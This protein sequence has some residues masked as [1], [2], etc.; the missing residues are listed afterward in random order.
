ME[1]Q[2]SCDQSATHHGDRAVYAIV[3]NPLATERSAIVRLPVSSKDTFEVSRLDEVGGRNGPAAVQQSVETVPTCPKCHVK[4]VLMFD[5]G[6]LPPVGA[7]AFRIS[8]AVAPPNNGADGV[9]EARRE[10]LRKLREVAHESL[11]VSNG[12]VSATFDTSTGKIKSISSNNIE[13]SIDHEW[14]YYR[15]YDTAFDKSE[16]DDSGQRSGA[17]IFRPS[18]PEELLTAL[19]PSP[20]GAKIVNTSVSIEVHVAFKEPWMKQVTRV[21]NDQP[22]IEVEYTIGPIPIEDGRGKEVVT[23]YRSEIR[24]KGVFFT[25]S[26]GREFQRRQRNS[27]PT[28]DLSVYEPVAGNYYPVNAAMYLEDDEASLAVLVDRSQGGASLFDGSLEL[29]VQRRIVADDGRGVDE[30]LNETV[31]GTA[32]YPPYGDSHRLGEGVVIRGTHRI[33]VSPS[34]KNGGIG[35]ASLCRSTMDSVFAQPVVL[36]GSAP[37]D[38][39][40]VFRRPVFS[41]I[42]QSFPPNVMLITFAKLPSRAMPTYLVRLAHQYGVGEDDGLSQPAEVDLASLF[43][44]RTIVGVTEKTLSGNLD[45]S[46]YLEGRKI[47]GDEVSSVVN[48][49]VNT[50]VVVT[51]MNIRTFEVSVQVALDASTPQY[52]ESKQF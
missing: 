19:S 12:L 8:K 11:E 33:L 14:G 16:V 7:V 21:L 10:V 3:Y 20:G 40:V 36:V 49:D 2:S 13:L 35:G 42:Q 26:N 22:Y 17:Y 37:V 23:R 50:T 31:G 32:P 46:D 4:H 30:A 27:R 18:E 6:I 34:A 39:P 41:A 52:T 44:Q 5:T 29:M 9:A 25:D 43:P 47:W 45:W 28:W 1:S 15:S 48:D 38:Q 24:S 51:A